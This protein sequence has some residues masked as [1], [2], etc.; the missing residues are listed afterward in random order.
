M[1]KS[2]HNFTE[3]AYDMP[4]KSKLWQQSSSYVLILKKWTK[5]LN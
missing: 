2:M 3:N 1:Y 5:N 4:P